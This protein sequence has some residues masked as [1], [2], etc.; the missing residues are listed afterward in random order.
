MTR[1]ASRPRHRP[2]LIVGAAVALLLAWAACWTHTAIAAQL[3]PGGYYWY[4]PEHEKY[5]RTEFYSAPDFRSAPV[6]ISRTQRFRYVAGSRGWALL[7]FDSGVHAYIHLRI[8]R[9]LQWV[10]TADDPWYEFQRASVFPEEPERIEA[11]LKPGRPE[12][13]QVDT[14]IP[15]WKRYKDSWDLDHTRARGENETRGIDPDKKTQSRY[16]LLPPILPP[17]QAGSGERS[18]SGR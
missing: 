13:A 7:E 9:T 6:K 11:R 8:L 4:A 16:P 1:P 3:E 17:P 5:L 18:E 12:P 15:I 2:G 10:P 14:R